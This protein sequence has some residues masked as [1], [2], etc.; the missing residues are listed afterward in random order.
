MQLAGVIDDIALAEE[1]NAAAATAAEE[2]DKL[3]R[4]DLE[5]LVEATAANPERRMEAVAK[6]AEISNRGMK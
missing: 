4:T 3:L 1:E 5:R 2:E 6:A